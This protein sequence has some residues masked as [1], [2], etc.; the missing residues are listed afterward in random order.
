MTTQQSRILTGFSGLP[1]WVF[2]AVYGVTCVAAAIPLAFEYQPLR[3]LVGY[4]A[5]LGIPAGFDPRTATV[6]WALLLVAPLCMAL[7]YQFGLW[8][9]RGKFNQPPTPL[10]SHEP[11]FWAGGLTFLASAVWAFWTLTNAGAFE[12]LGNWWDYGAWVTVR[13]ALF[14]SLGFFEFTNLYVWLP[15]SCAWVVISTWARGGRVRWAGM[16][17]IL[18][19]CGFALVLFQKKALMVTLLLVLF[20]GCLYARRRGVHGSVLRR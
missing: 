16:L 3:I 10:L 4:F 6:F 13:W 5:G 17:A 18:V 2:L 9:S 19:T 20:A 12:Q 14:E 7:G 15:L 1:L 8:A 11:G